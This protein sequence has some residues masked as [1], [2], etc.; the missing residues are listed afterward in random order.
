MLKSSSRN[1]KKVS[2]RNESAKP[3]N[4]EFSKHVRI[5]EGL[6]QKENPCTD[7]NADRT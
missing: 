1:F 2:S 7:K 6:I 5:F 4:L 3:T